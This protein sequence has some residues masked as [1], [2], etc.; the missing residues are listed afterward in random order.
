MSVLKS[1]I[2]GQ[3]WSNNLIEK[4]KIGIWNGK[5]VVLRLSNLD[6]LIRDCVIQL[7][8]HNCSKCVE[9]KVETTANHYT[10]KKPANYYNYHHHL[11]LF[12]YSAYVCWEDEESEKKK[13]FFVFVSQQK[14]LH[15]INIKH[16]LK[17]RK[18]TKCICRFVSIW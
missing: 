13:N 14:A 10:F 5:K 1:K 8:V 18:K 9:S 17:L 16:S 6:E 3:N 4:L 11:L 7:K 2:N 15:L 12:T